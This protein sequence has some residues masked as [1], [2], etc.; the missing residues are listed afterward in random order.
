M[1]TGLETMS[2]V[3][4]T[5]VVAWYTGHQVEL[6]YIKSYS[7]NRPIL[8]ALGLWV[9]F[10]SKLRTGFQNKKC[11]RHLLCVLFSFRCVCVQR[12]PQIVRKLNT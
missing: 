1:L 4:E 9:F 12:L 6:L 11:K 3:C 5:A 10:I 8:S 7:I 2:N